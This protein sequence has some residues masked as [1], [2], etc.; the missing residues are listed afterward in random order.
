MRLDTPGQRH[1]GA[2]LLADEVGETPR[3]L[4]FVGLRK[5]GVEH[6]RD[7][8]AEHAITEKF[9]TLIGQGPIGRGTNMRQ[10]EKEMRAI[11]EGMAERGLKFGQIVSL[12]SA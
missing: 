6:R 3:K 4:A 7:R 12:F 1:G 2:T 5:C 10:G 11:G 8:D 9:E